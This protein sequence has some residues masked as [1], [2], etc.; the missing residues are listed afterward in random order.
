[1]IKWNDKEPVKIEWQGKNIVAVFDY[2]HYVW[3]AFGSCYS[4]GAWIGSLPWRSGDPWK[5]I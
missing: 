2:M 5:G 4:S 3:Q 1:M